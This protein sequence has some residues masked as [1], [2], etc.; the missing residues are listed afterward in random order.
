MSDKRATARHTAEQFYH[1][2]R[3]TEEFIDLCRRDK[4]EVLSWEDSLL[5][6]ECRILTQDIIDA[7]EG[8]Q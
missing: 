8:K 6:D 3:L 5:L 2:G 4:T 7:A 1:W